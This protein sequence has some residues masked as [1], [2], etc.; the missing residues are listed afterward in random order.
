MSILI[1]KDTRVLVQGITGKEGSFH[2]LQMVEYGTN[3]VAGVTPGKGGQS[4]FRDP[5][6]TGIPIF[7]TVQEAKS[8]EGA[9]AS[10]VF[11]PPQFAQDAIIE[12]AEAGLDPVVCIT[13]GIPVHDMIEVKRY[14]KE[15]GTRLIG[16]NCPG[17]ITPEE[18]KLGIMPGHIHKKGS[19]G[20]ISRSGSLT[21]EAV[22]QLT[23]LGIGQ[24]TSVGI[25]GDM[26][27]GTSITDLLRL[28]KD[29]PE[30]E[31]ILIIGEIGGEEEEMAAEYIREDFGKPVMAYVAGRTAPPNRR[32]GHAGA[33]IEG[34]RGRYE[35]K[36]ESL[37]SSGAYIIITPAEIGKTVR[38]LITQIRR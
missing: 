26:I 5:F 8:A 30:T 33:I 14:L 9:D 34:S 10:I 23:E 15:R 4:F 17:I 27:V 7:N 21:Y 32:M 1:N 38:N 2:T 3:V 36:V 6:G 24:S 20:V 31:A 25:G 12:A 18:S 13:D 37:R 35:R 11:V 29:D 22:N 28:F 16:P 19:V